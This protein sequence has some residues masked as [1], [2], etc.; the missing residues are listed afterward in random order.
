MFLIDVFKKIGAKKYLEAHTVC[1]DMI[2]KN[3]ND[4]RPY[5]A[6]GIIAFEHNNFVKAEELYVRA[7]ELDSNNAAYLATYA[8]LLSVLGRQNEARETAEKAAEL[9]M[10]DPLT[11]DTIAVV[12]SRAGFHERAIPFFKKAI[13]F[14]DKPSNFHYNL[15][16]SLQFSGRF[17]EAKEAY[18]ATIER[19][20]DFSKAY[21]GLVALEKQT[22]ENSLLTTLETLFKKHSH[23]PDA[24]LHLGHAIAKTYEDF[25]E[26]DHSLEWLK[27]AKSM[28]KNRFPIDLSAQ[29]D[30]FEAAKTTIN[31]KQPKDTNYNESAPIF[32]VGLPRTGTTLVDRILSSHPDVTAAGELNVFAAIVKRLANTEDN[33]VL[34]A[35]TLRSVPAEAL[36]DIGQ[37]YMTSTKALSRGAQRFTD[38]MPLNFF[39][40]GLINKALPNA[41]IV[42][43][44]RGAM[45]SCVSNY[46]Q[47]FSTQFSYYNYTYDL[48]STAGF[49]RGYDELMAYWRDHLPA[50]RFMEIHYEDIVFDQEN[51][52]RQLLDFC[53]LSWDET[54]M[55]FHEN[56][57]PVSTASSVQVRQ[58]L[59]S[60]SIGRWK[61]YTEG[62]EP[63]KQALAELAE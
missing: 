20:P 32:V 35:E 57:A 43:L 62:L 6:L 63:L 34:D 11:A 44:R 8:Q 17:E 39:Y 12:F 1:L 47:L 2:R 26:Y 52:T 37:H 61:R 18:L 33:M 9:P 54:C 16:S 38:K 55:R 14:N 3:V 49:Y 48:E 13:E 46:R 23:D 41:R 59:Y 22:K 5:H 27:R 21:S 31:L 42:A 30:T 51:Q 25:G 53:G 28:N 40:A 4:P 7:T 19:D 24:T 60:G 58:P 29:K 50:D 10:H 45:D 56:Q 15:G 36:A